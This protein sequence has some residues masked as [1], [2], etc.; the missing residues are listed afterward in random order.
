MVWPRD[1]INQDL[2]N[3][4][5]G[6]EKLLSTTFFE[7]AA[8]TLGLPLL[9]PAVRA[10]VDWRYDVPRADYLAL[11]PEMHDDLVERS[12]PTDLAPLKAALPWLVS[13]LADTPPLL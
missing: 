5:V 7:H 12:D 11:K 10:N 3:S 9:A 6:I 8:E 13:Q 1:L 2:S 4:F